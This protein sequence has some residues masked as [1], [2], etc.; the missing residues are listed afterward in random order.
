M[1]NKRHYSNATSAVLLLLFLVGC[2][3]FS[4]TTT[5]NEPNKAR[6]TGI[7][8]HSSFPEA[9]EVAQTENKPIM[10]VFS[11]A[12][13]RRLTK[14]AFALP[15]V[16]E[17]LRNFVSMKIGAGQDDLIQR[18]NVQE[19]PT[20]VFTDAHGV[21][22]DR[23][24]GYRSGPSVAKILRSALIPVEAEYRL[25]IPSSGS[26]TATVTVAFK[27]IRWKSC[28]FG[29]RER[30]SQPSILEYNS[31]DGRP[32]WEKTEHNTWTINFRTA[33]IKT[34]TIKYAVPLSVLSSVRYNP[35]YASYM[36]DDHGVF[37]GRVLFAAPI[38]FGITGKT[39][40]ELEIPS[41]WGVLTPWKQNGNL[42]FEADSIDEVIDSVF[43]I[44]E[45]Q[46]VKRN[47]GKHLIYAVHSG[48]KAKSPNLEQQADALTK[49]LGDYIARFG[50]FPA[51]RY[52]AISTDLT[53][54]KK[55]ITGSSTHSVGFVG[56]VNAG[57]SFV[58]H[59]AFHVWNGG[60]ISQKTEYE[61]WFKEGF[62]QY[63]GYLTPYRLGLYSKDV[64]AKQ[65]Q[66]DYAA[67][68]KRYGTPEDMALTRVKEELARREGYKQPES[69]RLWA[70]YFKGALVAALLDNE[71]RKRT[72]GVKNLDDLMRYVFHR[73]HGEKYSSE[74]ILRALNAVTGKDFSQFFAD[75]VYGKTKL[76]PL[77]IAE[78]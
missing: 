47:L 9:L 4:G 61:G 20:I 17:L 7:E 67:Y 74:D 63:Y 27:N 54:D 49:I 30:N 39:K 5:N 8:W 55:Y 22:Y 76:P 25:Q 51:K 73:F 34:A 68:L 19:F 70:M 78:D 37:D 36:C 45:F 33:G 56:P 64:L 24:L 71:M 23:F 13:S 1:K 14:R 53:R 28:T 32:G 75:F 77:S 16:K 26:T 11:A 2:A 66:R 58:A 31:S 52:L 21:E 60:V 40:I 38:D 12:S 57:Y 46:Y 15:E 6:A 59:E 29:F 65:L 50:D 10:L 3:E 41:G 18:Y 44:G 48:S 69:D 72:F 35:E 43:C 62:T 42:S